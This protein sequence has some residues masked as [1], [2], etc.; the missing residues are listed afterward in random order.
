[1][2]FGPATF[3][4]SILGTADAPPDLG[5]LYLTDDGGADWRPVPV[6]S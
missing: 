3:S 6:A 5:T 2:V 4:L 1:L